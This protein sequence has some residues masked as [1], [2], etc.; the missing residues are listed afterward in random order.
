MTF[1][2][3]RGASLTGQDVAH[4]LLKGLKGT[5]GPAAEPVGSFLPEETE[6]DALVIC[7]AGFCLRSFKLPVLGWH[8]WKLQDLHSSPGCTWQPLQET[9]ELAH[10]DCAPAGPRCLSCGLAW[11]EGCGAS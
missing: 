3:N 4:A 2:V 5:E 6:L 11:A 1:P 10:R 9:K 8:G 7:E